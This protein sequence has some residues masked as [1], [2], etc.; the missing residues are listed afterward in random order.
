[1]DIAG[2]HDVST[3]RGLQMLP[4]YKNCGCNKCVHESYFCTALIELFLIFLSLREF[5][6]DPVDVVLSGIREEHVQVVVSE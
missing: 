6:H 2:T 1:M 3:F 4:G 5:P